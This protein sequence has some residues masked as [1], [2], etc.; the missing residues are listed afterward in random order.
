[1][2]WR[3]AGQAQQRYRVKQRLKSVAQDRA[4]TELTKAK[5]EFEAERA[6]FLAQKRAWHMHMQSFYQTPALWLTPDSTAL[7]I[8]PDD[9][10]QV[11]ATLLAGDCHKS[12][13]LCG[14]VTFWLAPTRLTTCKYVLRLPRLLC[15]RQSPDCCSFVWIFMPVW[16]H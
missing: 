1:M 3:L 12:L 5:A 11:M 9:S 15:C 7:F 16:R 6:A 14:V 10:Y 13:L 8:S 4:T 2:F